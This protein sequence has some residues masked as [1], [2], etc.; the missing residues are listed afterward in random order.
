MPPIPHNDLRTFLAEVLPRRG[1]R[2]EGFRKVHSQVKSRLSDRLDELELATLDDYR[3]H[4]EDHPAEW[5]HFDE[6]LYITISRFYRDAE[7]WNGLRNRV[8]PAVAEATKSADRNTVHALSIGSASG[9]EPYTLRLCWE[10]DNKRPWRDLE[11]RVDAIDAAEHMVERAH[12][13]EYP[14]GNLKELPGDWIE[15]AFE[16]LDGTYHLRKKYRRGVSF[17]VADLREYDP[18]VTYDLVFCRN[19][20]FMYFDEQ[21]RNTTL[22]RLADWT[23][24]GGALVVGN[25]DLVPDRPALF[26]PWPRVPHVWKRSG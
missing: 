22:E 13:A 9:E 23:H 8:L 21:A 18:P 15:R 12:R 17:E 24:P 26:V 3:Q 20:A 1:Y 5:D 14:P 7:T 4:L 6:F 11:L 10:L 19:L 25:R 16:R 2:P